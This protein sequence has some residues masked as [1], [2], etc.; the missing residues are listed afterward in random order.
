MVLAHYK[1]LVMRQSVKILTSPR[2][3]KDSD[4]A[5][6]IAGMLCESNQESAFEKYDFGITSVKRFVALLKQQWEAIRYE[7]QDYT[8][9]QISAMDEFI[10]ELENYTAE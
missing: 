8:S 1:Q 4:T 7:E 6:D 9:D 3:K 10:C 2:F 5:I